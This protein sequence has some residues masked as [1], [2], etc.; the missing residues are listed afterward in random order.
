MVGYQKSQ[1]TNINELIKTFPLL[2]WTAAQQSN[3]VTANR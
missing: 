2:K 3:N 1:K